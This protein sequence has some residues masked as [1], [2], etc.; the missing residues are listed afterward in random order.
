[1]L[2]I[3]E[4]NLISLEERDNVNVLIIIMRVDN[5]AA[6]SAIHLVKVA[7]MTPKTAVPLALMY[8]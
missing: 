7:K 4:L 3:I 2:Q 1:M 6:P 8:H 5:E